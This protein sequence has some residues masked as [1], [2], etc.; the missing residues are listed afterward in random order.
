MN[1]M[2]A[3]QAQVSAMQNILSTLKQPSFRTVANSTK[4]GPTIV[5]FL[6]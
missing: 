5:A 3:L 2:I 6:V 1:A 4:D